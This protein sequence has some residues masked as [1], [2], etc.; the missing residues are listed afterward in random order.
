MSNPQTK[1]EIS[2]RAMNLQMITVSILFLMGLWGCLAIY[3]ATVFSD[4][5]FL[6]AGKQLLWLFLGLIIMWITSKVPFS[7]YKQHLWSLA[8]FAYFLLLLVLMCGTR[9]NGMKGWFDLGFGYLQPS[10]IAKPLFILT[11]CAIATLATTHLKLFLYLA[12]VTI[13]WCI[14]LALQPDFG[15]LIIYIAGFLT[16]YILAGGKIIYLFPSFLAMIP[17]AVYI[18]QHKPYVA[19]RIAGFLDPEK[20]ASGAG[21]HILQFQ[22]TLAR[23]GFSGQSWGHSLWANAYLPLSYSDSSFASMVEAIG[24]AGTIPVIVGFSALAYAGYRLS[25]KA[26]GNFKKL[27]ICAMPILITIQALVHM[28]VNVTML[29]ATGITLPIFSY[30]GSSLISIM[31]SFGV[32]LSAA[33]N[34]LQ[35]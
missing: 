14:P 8:A 27:F 4:A 15:T 22:Y 30:G 6:Y 19:A 10:E 25:L 17:F 7:V 29:P 3:N 31:L 24:L 1:S 5:P 35:I 20:T 21:W 16:V 34:E 12:G 11:L 9:V 32:I 28:S 18:Y 13:L 26:Q 33:K 23:G 2:S